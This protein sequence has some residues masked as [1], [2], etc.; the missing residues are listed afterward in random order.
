[1]KV[2]IQEPD[3]PRTFKRSDCKPGTVYMKYT[4]HVVRDVT[5]YLCA[6]PFEGGSVEMYHL[7]SGKSLLISEADEFIPVEA[8]VSIK[9][10]FS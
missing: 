1:M 7:A 4:G 3:K 6:L 9:S 10:P 8:T 2:V 5:P